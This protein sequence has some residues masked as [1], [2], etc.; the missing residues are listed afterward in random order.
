ML[1][2]V[3]PDRVR[4]ARTKMG[5]SQR[6][7]AELLGCSTRAVQEW[8]SAAGTG[9]PRPATTRLLAEKS[10]REIAWFFEPTLEAA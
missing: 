7:L 1:L 6:E 4:E 3:N 9:K 5:L 8:E 10:G 2:R